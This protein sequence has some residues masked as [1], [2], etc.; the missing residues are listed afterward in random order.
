MNTSARNCFMATHVTTF[1]YYDLGFFSTL[2]ITHGH[3]PL[4]HVTSRTWQLESLGRLV[5]RSL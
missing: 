5:N 4:E 3:I 1:F 2:Q